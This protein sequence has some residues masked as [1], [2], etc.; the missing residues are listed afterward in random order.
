MIITDCYMIDTEDNFVLLRR[1]EL[2]V[3]CPGSRRH[4]VYHCWVEGKFQVMVRPTLFWNCRLFWEAP[5]DT[6]FSLHLLQIQDFSP[7]PSPIWTKFFCLFF[8]CVRQLPSLLLKVFPQLQEVE[9]WRGK[10]KENKNIWIYMD[11]GLNFSC[12]PDT[13]LKFLFKLVSP[14]VQL[15]E[16][17]HPVWVF[18]KVR[19]IS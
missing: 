3:I 16:W 13:L 6:G 7:C 11:L 2:K 1:E 14:F 18:V 8:T 19:D 12:P 15:K 17:D 9:Q 4:Q 10:M 5:I